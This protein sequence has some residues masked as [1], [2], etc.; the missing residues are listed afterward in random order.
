M[1][2]TLRSPL[3]TRPTFPGVD[4]GS[5]VAAVADS[6]TDRIAVAMGLFFTVAGLM[7]ALTPAFF[8]AIVPPWLPPGERFWTYASG[9]A[10]LVVGPLLLIRRTRRGAAY[11]A[12][13]LLVAVY[14]ANLY[15]AWDWRDRTVSRQLV[16]YGRLPFQFLFIWLAWQVAR[17]TKPVD[18]ARPDDTP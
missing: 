8:D 10:E 6:R 17:R 14:P 12:M 9:L 13:V 7:H 18:P 11:A 16:A 3:R 15:M 2:R 1:G 5:S 4:P